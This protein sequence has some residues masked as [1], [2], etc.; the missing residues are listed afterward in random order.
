MGVLEWLAYLVKVNSAQT[1][2]GGEYETGY[3]A[4]HFKPKASRDLKASFLL[5]VLDVVFDVEDEASIVAAVLR[6][7]QAP[8]NHLEVEV[9]A[10][11]RRL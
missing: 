11:Y 2:V 1:A 5:E 6:T 4:S 7:P 3:V 9:R 10:V 8:P